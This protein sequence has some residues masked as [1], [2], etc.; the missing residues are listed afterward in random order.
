MALGAITGVAAVG[1]EGGPEFI[2]RVTIVGD[3]SYPTG[4]T[5]LFQAAV[6]AALGKGNLELLAVIHQGPIGAD[7]VIAYDKAN[8]KLTARV[9]STGVEVAGAVD[10]SG[11]TLEALI[12]AK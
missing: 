1:H 7:F 9:A 4:G 8:D 6:R 5:A 11:T 2:E 12:F 3:G 10:M